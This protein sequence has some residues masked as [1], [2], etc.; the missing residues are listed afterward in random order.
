MSALK[1]A[2]YNH[3]GGVGKTTLTVNLAFALKELGSKVLLV[4]TDPQC[5]LTSYLID[6]DKLD[7]MLDQSDGNSGTTIWSALRDIFNAQGHLRLI[8]PQLT[9]GLYLVPGDIRLAEYEEILQDSW[10]NCF[11]R[12]LGAV[13]ATLAIS[14]LVQ[15]I[16]DDTKADFV[17]YDSGPN[18]GPLNR[19][20]YL[21][22]DILIVPVALDKFSI[23]A[24]STLGEKLVSWLRDCETIASLL[25]EGSIFLRGKA[26]FAGCVPQKFKVYGQAMTNIAASF[27]P[28]LQKA[29]ETR[30]TKKLIKDF[31]DRIIRPI[32]HLF[33]EVQDFSGLS[34]AA[35]RDRVAMW[36]ANYSNQ[37]LARESHRVFIDMAH[38]ILALGAYSE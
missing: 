3:K 16:I 13:S 24:L 30:I 26:R 10:A 4:D 17:F 5:N 2:V 18:I 35:Q 9:R 29:I 33:G 21:D 8:R 25:P 32:S 28:D 36:N 27:I 20:I 34:A 31:P 15:N 37:H 12:R 23:R 19:I 7:K 6:D 22:C 38:K 11:R 1:I 14:E